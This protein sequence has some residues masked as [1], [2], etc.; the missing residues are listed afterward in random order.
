M[1]IEKDNIVMVGALGGFM[2][3]PFDLHMKALALFIHDEE[4]VNPKFTRLLA[5]LP[6]TEVRKGFNKRKEKY[7]RFPTISASVSVYYNLSKASF[8]ICSLF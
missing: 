8:C 7:K 4:K 5:R 2:E 6:V 3:I 1:A